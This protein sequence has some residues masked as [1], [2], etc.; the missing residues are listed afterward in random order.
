LF[1]VYK[2]E[3]MKRRGRGRT[4]YTVKTLK[5]TRKP[6][7]QRNPFRSIGVKQR[8]TNIFVGP[9]KREGITSIENEERVR[10]GKHLAQLSNAGMV[11][12][13]KELGIIPDDMGVDMSQFTGN[14]AALPSGITNLEDVQREADVA[15]QIEQFNAGIL[16]QEHREQKALMDIAKKRKQSEYRQKIIQW[17]AET[18]ELDEVPAEF[19]EEVAAYYAKN[20]GMKE[21]VAE[22]RKKRKEKEERE[23]TKKLRQKSYWQTSSAPFSSIIPS[24]PSSTRYTTNTGLLQHTTRD[25]TP[26]DE[27]RWEAF[28]KELDEGAAEGNGFINSGWRAPR[29]HKLVR[30]LKRF[31]IEEE[32][33]K[34]IEDQQQALDDRRS[35]YKDEQ[36]RQ[37]GTAPPKDMVE[38]A[39]PKL[40]EPFFANRP[41]VQRFRTTPDFGI[42]LHPF[43]FPNKKYL[44]HTGVF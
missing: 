43:V 31:E 18:D 26:T 8:S 20:A 37:R 13:M 38:R 34:I 5:T 25:P 27:D 41:L 36:T 22:K 2:K 16:N 29:L 7:F 1:F 10:Q 17:L 4:Y 9:L 23:E 24:A 42:T 12:Q 15:H 35:M 40:A 11:K 44:L 30:P 14:V 3:I 21:R 6:L 32:P 39:M 28:L 33:D 19:A